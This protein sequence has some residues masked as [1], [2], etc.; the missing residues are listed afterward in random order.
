EESLL[1]ERL[2]EYAERY[3]DVTVRRIVVGGGRAGAPGRPGRRCVGA[4]RP[5]RALLSE[6]EDAQL[7]VVGSHGRG[8]FTGMLL[9]STSNALIHTVECPIV[10]IRKR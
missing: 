8:G 1:A 5:G 7:V 4:A 2:A 6:S 3:P 9:G 10:V